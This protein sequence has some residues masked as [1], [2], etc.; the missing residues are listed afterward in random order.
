MEYVPGLH[1]VQGDPSVGPANEPAVQR[2]HELVFAGGKVPW[3][4]GHREHEDD[5]FLAENVPAAQGSHGAP[6]T[7]F[8][9]AGQGMHTVPAGEGAPVCPGPHAWHVVA[10]M[11]LPIKPGGHE[12]HTV[13]PS[14]AE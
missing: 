4:L 5:E 2:E 9:P 3:P 6:P 13:A 14:P 10:P 8:V 11:A 12:S 1:W 7:P